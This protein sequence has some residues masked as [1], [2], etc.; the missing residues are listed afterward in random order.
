VVTTKCDVYSFGVVSL[1]IVLGR[2]PREL[3]SLASMGQHHEFAMEDML[4]QRPSSPTKAEKKEIALLV[5]VA[6]A[7]LQTSQAR[8]TMQDVYQK[9]A[10]NKHSSFASPS[11]AL[12][13]DETTEGEM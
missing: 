9:L 13:V 2:Y 10:S 7:C 1:E 6:F 11:H 4:D 12:T 8:P 3:Q 5:E